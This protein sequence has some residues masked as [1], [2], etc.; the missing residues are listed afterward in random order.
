MILRILSIILL[1]TL[2]LFGQSEVGVKHCTSDVNYDGFVWVEYSELDQSFCCYDNPFGLNKSLVCPEY[3]TCPTFTSHIVCDSEG[4]EYLL[5]KTS[6]GLEYRDITTNELIEQGNGT[7][8][9]LF[10]KFSPPHPDAATYDG[11]FTHYSELGTGSNDPDQGF[12]LNN[13]NSYVVCSDTQP[14]DDSNGHFWRQGTPDSFTWAN[15]DN[16]VAAYPICEGVDLSLSNCKIDYERICYSDGVDTLEGYVKYVGMTKY[17]LSLDGAVVDGFEVN[18][19]YCN[20]KT[21]FFTECFLPD[22]YAIVWG[23]AGNGHLTSYDPSTGET[24]FHCDLPIGGYALAFKNDLTEPTLFYQVGGN[25]YKSSPED[26]CG[27]FAL[28]GSTAVATSSYPCFDFDPAGRLLLGDGKKVWET[29]PDTG[30][31]TFLG[32]LIDARDGANLNVSPGDWFF[33]PNGQWFMMARDNRGASFTDPNGD[34]YCTGTALW[35]IDPVTLE[36][37]RVNNSCSPVS[38]TGA[39]WLSAGQYLLSTSNG[40]T[41]VHNT[42]T[43]TWEVE[44]NADDSGTNTGINDLA[45]QWVIPKA[46]VL[47]WKIGCDADT[48]QCGNKKIYEFYTDES[49]IDTCVLYQAN[50]S[51]DWGVCEP[52]G[53]PFVTDA[54]SQ[55]DIEYKSDQVWREG[56]SKAGY[57]L[58]RVSYDPSCNQIYEYVY[59]SLTLQTPATL[60]PSEFSPLPCGSSIRGSEITTWCDLDTGLE[61]FRREYNLSGAVVW[62]DGSGNIAEP[63]NKTAGACESSDPLNPIINERVCIDGDTYIFQTREVNIEDADG[64]PELFSTQCIYFNETGQL[65]D[66]GVVLSPNPKPA[67]EPTVDYLGDCIEGDPVTYTG[68]ESDLCYDSNADGDFN[69]PAIFRIASDGSWEYLDRLGNVLLGTDLG[70]CNCK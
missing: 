41:Y 43:E 35:K 55:T 6:E 49:G 56:C 17:I 63:P 51:G 42:Y 47:G 66:S 14:A 10:S 32:N 33:D 11:S 37:S 19:K 1:S 61:V 69:M 27:T 46:K 34:P 62:F 38:G 60:E 4:K 52:K 8:W 20:P 44:Y 7:T 9:T 23:W 67:G 15:Y 57:T 53:N 28:V 65:W 13:Y 45:S 25:L 16:E 70:T 26:P 5:C 29:D 31:S 30:A 68:H 18:S 59:G 54:T 50:L 58:W 39:T 40:L 48:L 22:Q 12:D 2:G 64:L 21:E 3:Y 24:T 36:A